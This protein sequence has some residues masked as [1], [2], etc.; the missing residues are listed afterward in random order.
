MNTGTPEAEEAVQQVEEHWE[1]VDDH[2]DSSQVITFA[3][4]PHVDGETGVYS[5][6]FDEH[7]L[8]NAAVVS[9]LVYEVSEDQK[10]LLALGETYD[11]YGDWETG[12][13]SDGFN[14]QWLSLP[15]GQNLCTYVVSYESDDYVIYTS[16]INLNG[17]D[18]FLRMRQSLA[19]GSVQVEG[20][21]DGIG[22]NGAANRTE[23]KS[24]AT[25]SRSTTA[26]CPTAATCTTSALRTSLATTWSRPPSPSRST[27]TATCTSWSSSTA[28][29]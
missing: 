3:E 26:P 8:S 12:E 4:D 24:P 25:P 23:L 22:Q 19:D 20:V 28:V 10:N 16:P 21:W 29:P 17:K 14:G 9:A 7:G 27:P 11:I 18:T 2:T 1:Y 15:D 6:T 5:F 13:F